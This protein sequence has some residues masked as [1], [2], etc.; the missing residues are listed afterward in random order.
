MNDANKNPILK[1][2]LLHV[3]RKMFIIEIF[4]LLP[5]N[6]VSYSLGVSLCQ[7]IH[8]HVVN[9]ISIHTSQINTYTYINNNIIEI[10]INNH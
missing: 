9:T 10:T 7:R 2:S 6:F 3:L 5:Y 1:T 4:P 8:T